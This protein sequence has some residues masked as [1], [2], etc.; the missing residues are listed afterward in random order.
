MNR[1][2]SFNRAAVQTFFNNLREVLTRNKFQPHQIYNVDESGFSTV[3]IPQRILTVR[4]QHQTGR[5]TSAER[6]QLTRV[7]CAFSAQVCINLHF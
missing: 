6:G 1:I 5:I 3:Q 4:G 2:I 7:I